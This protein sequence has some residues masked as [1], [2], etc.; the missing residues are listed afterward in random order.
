MRDIRSLIV[1]DTVELSSETLS[2]FLGMR[3]LLAE[4][5]RV[6]IENAVLGPNGLTVTYPLFTLDAVIF[7][8]EYSYEMLE[9]IISCRFD[10]PVSMYDKDLYEPPTCIMVTNRL[11][12][13]PRGWEGFNVKGPFK[14]YFRVK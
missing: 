13:P 1:E 8:G 14:I 9:F 6:D 12:S 3:E 7:P 4:G 5:Y 11:V 2:D 10:S